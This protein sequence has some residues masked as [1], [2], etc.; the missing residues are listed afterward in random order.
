MADLAATVHI[1]PAVARFSAQLVE[2]TRGD[3]G[4]R[5]G[6]S[7]RGA[8]S[9]MRIAKVYAA[10]QG[11]HYVVPDDIKALAIPVWAHRIVL[12]PEAEFS[13]VTAEQIVKNALAGVEAPLARATA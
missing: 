3:E 6:V 4:A 13:G 8:I 12:D 1:D 11:R 2:A 10:A 7:V 5:L 9:M